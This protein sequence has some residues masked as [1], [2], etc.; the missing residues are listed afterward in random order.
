ME[1]RVSLGGAGDMAALESLDA[2]LRDEPR[3]AGRVRPLPSPPKPGEMGALAEAL[4]VAVG[5]GGA[6]SVLA[7]AI[8]S[9]L[10]QPRRSDI[11]VRVEVPGER[12]VEVGGD[13][14][15]AAEVESLLR[16]AMDSRA[17]QGPTQD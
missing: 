2:W 13:R 10:A 15:S 12:I 17:P 5:S 9:W 4:L 14:I 7:S 8:S 16:E 3:L 11:Q 1:L 6:L